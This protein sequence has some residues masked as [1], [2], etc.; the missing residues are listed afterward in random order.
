V[1]FSCELAGGAI[2][3]NGVFLGGYTDRGP[4]H[5]LYW[6]CELEVIK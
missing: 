4:M 6:T 1:H 5:G 3:Q 2:E